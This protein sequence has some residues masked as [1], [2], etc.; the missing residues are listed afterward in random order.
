MEI[1]HERKNYSF[2]AESLFINLKRRR[3]DFE[4]LSRMT[5]PYKSLFFILFF[6]PGGFLK[7]ISLP[8][9]INRYDSIDVLLEEEDKRDLFRGIKTVY[10]P[11]YRVYTNG[12]IGSLIGKEKRDIHQFY[13]S[14]EFINQCNMN[15]KKS[16]SAPLEYD[17][18]FRRA[19]YDI[20]ETFEIPEENKWLNFTNYASTEQNTNNALSKNVTNISSLDLSVF[21]HS[22][23]STQEIRK[24]Q[25]NLFLLK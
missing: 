12:S 15:Q 21:W 17:D 6:I 9:S 14:H 19:N 20:P 11:E 16:L 25:G 18:Q 22:Q 24:I 8:L 5:Q 23:M 1:E 3:N 7:L 2:P 13:N 10:A 4:V